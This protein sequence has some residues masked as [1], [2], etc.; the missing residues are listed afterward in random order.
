MKSK[1]GNSDAVPVKSLSLTWLAVFLLAMTWPLAAEEQEPRR[2]GLTVEIDIA[3]KYI[4]HG[5]DVFDNDAAYFPALTL[6]LFQTGFSI[7]VD[8]ALSFANTGQLND[9]HE[10]NYSIC[11]EHS[12]FEGNW[13]AVDGSLLW[14][15]MTCPC[16][17]SKEGV[18]SEF[19]LSIAMPELIP[20]GPSHLVPSYTATWDTLLHGDEYFVFQAVG[21]SYELPIP[22]FLPGNDEQVLAMAVETEHWSTNNDEID[23]GWAHVTFS[24]ELPFELKTVEITPYIAY[25]IST[26]ET[27]NDENELYGGVSFSKS[28]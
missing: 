4:D 2:L 27:V 7:T 24:F 5:A 28:F 8:A 6:D 13:Y 11:Y 20:L 3:S 9:A 23:N 12:F 1:S 21:L 17:P 19:E 22:A 14:G 10:L 18:V 15:V 16:L 25:Q 26:E